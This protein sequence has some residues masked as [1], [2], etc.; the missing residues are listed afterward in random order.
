MWFAKA[1]VKVEVTSLHRH[2]PQAKWGISFQTAA[3]IG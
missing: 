1:F 3:V 2:Q